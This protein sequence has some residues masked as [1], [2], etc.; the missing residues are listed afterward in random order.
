MLELPHFIK[1]TTV[2]CQELDRITLFL[3]KKLKIEEMLRWTYVII[4]LTSTARPNKDSC[5]K[6]R[7]YNIF[8]TRNTTALIKTIS[9]GHYRVN[10]HM[11][12]K[13]SWTV[14]AICVNP[15]RFGKINKLYFTLPK[16]L[17]KI[18]QVWKHEVKQITDLDITSRWAILLSW[19]LHISLE[20][21]TGKNVKVSV[22]KPI[23]NQNY[24]H[25]P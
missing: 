4:S 17:A 2:L 15:Q 1:V 20:L 23:Q 16:T 7:L 10:A 18:L 3:K 9:E 24:T 5:I 12:V 13:Q 11:K 25:P 19:N 6:T 8:K 21:N 22:F 14:L